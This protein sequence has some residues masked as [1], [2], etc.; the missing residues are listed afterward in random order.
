M[1]CHWVK[2]PEDG[3][4]CFIPGCWGG[5]SGPEGCTCQVEG[6]RLDRVEKEAADAAETIRYL[7]AMLAYE[8]RHAGDLHR[9]NNRLRDE[10]RALRGI[11]P[12]KKIEVSYP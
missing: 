7:R 6:S 8:R 2:D 4:L 12:K 1:N 5:V 9:N 11:G 3:F 10:I